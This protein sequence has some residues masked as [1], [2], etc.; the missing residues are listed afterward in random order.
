MESVRQGKDEYAAKANGLL[1]NLESFDTFF[2]LKLAELIFAPAEQFS[3]NLQAKD[4]LVSEAIK[5]S[6]MLVKHY[7]SLRTEDAFDRFYGNVLE[8]SANVTGEPVLPRR[9][10]APRRLDDGSEPHRYVTAK[11][12]YRHE[13]FLVL[14][15]AQG[16]IEK[17]F[18]QPDLRIVSDIET[19]LLESC[20]G[21]PVESSPES[22][23]QYFS[24]SNIDFNRLKLHLSMLPDALST[25]FGSTVNKVTHVRTLVV[26]LQ[27]S[28]MME[29]MLG[30]VAKL[31]KAYLTFPVSSATAERAFSSLRRI[32]TFLR[33]SMTSCRL[34]NLFLLYVHTGRTDALDMVEIGKQFVAVN[35]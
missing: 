34:N 19:L 22:V 23:T 17:R 9:R 3:V 12:K 13:Y 6:K 32:K 33:S 10:K 18:D 25:A 26:A 29:Q 8:S 14:E 30:E 2:G 31:V 1:S 5:G 35:S 24:H 20:N 15:L 16:E 28:S 21:E 11:D 4:T 27:G 7:A